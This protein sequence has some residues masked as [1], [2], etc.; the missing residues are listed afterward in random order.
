MRCADPVFLALFPVHQHTA[1][2]VVKENQAMQLPSSCSPVSFSSSQNNLPA[3]CSFLAAQSPGGRPTSLTNPYRSS[4]N[5][6]P[7]FSHHSPPVTCCWVL[8][9]PWLTLNEKMVLANYTT[10]RFL[11]ISLAFCC[12]FSWILLFAKL[13]SQDISSHE[14]LESIIFLWRQIHVLNHFVLARWSPTPPKRKC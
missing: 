7:A 6:V 4:R 9:V 12:Q 3:L 13:L 2:T 1:L 14:E 5:Q 10:F 11:L 8:T